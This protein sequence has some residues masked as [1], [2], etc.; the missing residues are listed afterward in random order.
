M[1][2]AQEQPFSDKGHVHL[3]LPDQDGHVGVGMQ[4][5]I[6]QTDLEPEEMAEAIIQGILKDRK[7]VDKPFTVFLPP[8]N[9]A[10]FPPSVMDMI[11][12][13]SRLNISIYA[14]KEFS[15]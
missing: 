1:P 9:K 10:L 8:I 5:L 3:T 4:T 12:R 6:F 14:C 2:R 13:L 7:I 11:V 15:K